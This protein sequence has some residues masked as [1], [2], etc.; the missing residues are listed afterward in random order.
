[1]PIWSDY[2]FTVID[3]GLRFRGH[4]ILLGSDTLHRSA[5]KCVLTHLDRFLR[6]NLSK[7]LIE[8]L[9]NYSTGVLVEGAIPPKSEEGG[10]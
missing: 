4:P 7:Q 2:N 3:T 10:E 1:M 9:I 8:M 6:K 5:D